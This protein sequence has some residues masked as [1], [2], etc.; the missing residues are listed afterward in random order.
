[1]AF[2]ISEVLKTQNDPLVRAIYQSFIDN[3]PFIANT[4]FNNV[5]G[6]S[7]DRNRRASL[8]GQAFRPLNGS[9]TATNSTT[10]RF[11]TPIAHAGALFQTDDFLKKADPSRIADELEQQVRAMTMNI[12]RVAFKGDKGA[13]NEFDG[14]QVLTGADGGANPERTGQTIVNGAGGGLAG[15]SLAKLDEAIVKTKGSNKKIYMGE[16]LY[17]KMQKASRDSNVGGRLN[18]V[19][20]TFGQMVLSYD[21]IAIELAG[22]DVDGSQILDFGEA[23]T[24]TSVYVVAHESGPIFDQVGGID[25]KEIEAEFSVS[26]SMAWDLSLSIRDL[27]SVQRLSD[28][29][30]LAITA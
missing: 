30:D 5:Q 20:N 9:V 27:R 3:A 25:Q 24:T 14:L 1:M 8:P 11:N 23:N 13:N 16:D 10:K 2:P 26:I 18:Y 21:G 6:T 12:N 22:E 29:G 15:L 28:I 17:I 19:P 4:T 7:V